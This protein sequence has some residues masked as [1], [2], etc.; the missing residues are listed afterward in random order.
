MK[1]LLGR[2]MI[3]SALAVIA[4][5]DLALAQKIYVPRDNSNSS[6]GG[7]KRKLYIPQVPNQYSRSP[8]SQHSNVKV[9][10]PRNKT[11]YEKTA[12]ER[13][14]ERNDAFDRV[15]RTNIELATKRS[16][17]NMAIIKSQREARQKARQ[18]SRIAYAEKKR[19]EMAQ[20]EEGGNSELPPEMRTD[21]PS[22]NVGDRKVY[23]HQDKGQDKPDIPPRIFNTF[24]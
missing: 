4:A 6:E 2:V 3:L 9:F 17:Q 19:M 12:A 16:E 15:Q 14:A 8:G 22:V 18:E 23:I 1:G 20:N 7:E 21:A 11:G 10:E 13:E 24:Q 5:P